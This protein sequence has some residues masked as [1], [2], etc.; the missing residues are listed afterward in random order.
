[1]KIEN[2]RSNNSL[3]VL[4]TANSRQVMGGN[5]TLLSDI[6]NFLSDPATQVAS[7]TAPNGAYVVSAVKVTRP[8]LK[9]V[10]T[11]DQYGAVHLVY[12]N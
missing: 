11:V 1:M 4:N 3:G 7:T 5:Q 6:S 12:A 8:D 10:Q 2:L 9:I